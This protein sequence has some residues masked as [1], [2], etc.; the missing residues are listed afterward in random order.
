MGEAMVKVL[1][2]LF[3]CVLSS[4]VAFAEGD[5]CKDILANGVWDY[6]LGVNDVHNVSAFLNWY[7]STNSGKSGETKKQSLTG[8]AVYEGAPLS[9]GLSNDQTQNNEFFSKLEKLN[10]GY[11]QYDQTV[12]NFVRTASAVIVKAWSDC[13]GGSGGGIKASLKFTEEPRDL[14]LDLRYQPIDSNSTKAQVTLDVP[15]SVKCPSKTVTVPNVGTNVRCARKTGQ[16]GAIILSSSTVI[17]PDKTLR[18]FA[19]LIR[20]NLTGKPYARCDIIEEI[21]NGK[22]VLDPAGEGMTSGD[23]MGGGKNSTHL[24]LEVPVGYRLTNV[25]AHCVKLDGDNPCAFVRGLTPSWTI[26]DRRVDANPTT[27]SDRVTVSLTGTKQK[28]IPG[29]DRVKHPSPLSLVYGKIFSVEFPNNALD[30]K[31]YCNAS[32]DQRIFSMSDIQKEGDQIYLRST[33]QGVTS[34]ILNLAVAP[35]DLTP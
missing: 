21:K 31:L 1:L 35:F 32:G 20:Q 14:I 25:Q 34:R 28:V 18:F 11:D 7:G 12:I 15:D 23:D 27:D 29:T 6:Q 4:S 22:D 2:G 3:L 24:S 9:L 26:P 5:R 30:V 10:A 17:N 19:A 8:S 13:M 33:Q 16:P